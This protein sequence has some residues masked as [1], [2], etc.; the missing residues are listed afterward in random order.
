MR[1]EFESPSENWKVTNREDAKSAKVK[2]EK[3]FLCALCVF[4][5]SPLSLSEGPSV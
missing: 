4:A 2:T 5:V 1:S 3:D